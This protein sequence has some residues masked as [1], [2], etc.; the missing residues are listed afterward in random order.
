MV[1]RRRCGR[2]AI[3]VTLVSPSVFFRSIQADS[4]TY[5]SAQPSLPERGPSGH[6]RCSGGAISLTEGR[7]DQKNR[8]QGQGLSCPTDI[9]DGLAAI[10]IEGV[11]QM[12]RSRS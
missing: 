8:G 9:G 7:A 1:S 2:P 12:A 6:C 11:G 4:R 10:R 5:Q 3:P